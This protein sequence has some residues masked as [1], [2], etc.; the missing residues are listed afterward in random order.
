MEASDTSVGPGVRWNE[1]QCT[2][3]LAQLEQLQT[4]VCM[5]RDLYLA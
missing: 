1:A 4:Q 2:S 3:A 5:F